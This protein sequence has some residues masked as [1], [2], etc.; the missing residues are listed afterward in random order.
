MIL[1]PRRNVSTP[2]THD[3]TD[4]ASSSRTKMRRSGAMIPLRINKTCDAQRTAEIHKPRFV[5]VANAAAMRF[6]AP[7]ISEESQMSTIATSNSTSIHQ[8][9]LFRA[10][11]KTI[12]PSMRTAG[13]FQT[14]PLLNINPRAISPAGPN[15]RI[16]TE[17]PNETR[18]RAPR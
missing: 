8:S 12:I 9:K 7:K 13:C 1:H 16:R 4:I 3:V 2:I 6:S 18:P 11:G 5:A 10:N 17:N 14:H 15:E